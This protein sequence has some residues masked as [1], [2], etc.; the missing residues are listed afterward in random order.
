MCIFKFYFNLFLERG[1]KREKERER[2]IDQS[3]LKCALA[4]SWTHNPGTCPDQELNP[5]HLAFRDKAQPSHT[6]QGCYVYFTTFFQTV[7]MTVLPLDRSKAGLWVAS[8]PTCG[9][10]HWRVTWTGLF[11]HHCSPGQP[12]TWPH[13]R[14][15]EFPD[16][17]GF[18]FSLDGEKSLDTYAAVGHIAAGWCFPLQVRCFL[19]VWQFRHIS[20]VLILSPLLGDS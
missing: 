16:F 8:I 15:I 2:N 4:G 9:L 19:H 13:A 12:Q 10:C 20:K 17:L 7:E 14:F 11:P 18:V 3:P 5:Q 1:E 6:S